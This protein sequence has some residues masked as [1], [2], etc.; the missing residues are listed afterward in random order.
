MPKR[1]KLTAKQKKLLKALPGASTVAE[2]GIQAGYKHR[3]SAHSALKTVQ[4][5]MPELMDSLGLTD[6][7]L[8]DNYLRPG[9][10]ATS[11][12]RKT[13]EIDGAYVEQI[14]EDP[15][16]HSR[17]G[18]LDMAFKVKGK[19]PKGADDPNQQPGGITFNLAIFA[20]AGARAFLA[21]VAGSGQPAVLD[22]ALHEDGG[23]AG[24]HRQSAETIP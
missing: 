3:Q 18:F 11:K 20:P 10:N 23:R 4:L 16:W 19:Y 21:S 12:Y 17:R 6:K 2:A 9:L 15:D 22:D 8:I 24:H 5:K 7:A 13:V 1:R 14:Q